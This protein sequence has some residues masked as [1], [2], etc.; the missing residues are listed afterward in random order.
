MRE[1]AVLFGRADSLVGI[2][3]DPPEGERGENLPA[4]VLLNGGVLHRVGPSRLHVKMARDLATLGFVV[5]RFDFSG[6]GD[7]QVRDDN[8]PFEKSAVRDTREAMDYLSAV[9]GAERFILIGICSGAVMSF[10]TACCDHRVTGVVVINARDYLHDVNGE[11]NSYINSRALA[12]HYWRIAFRSSFRSKN[13][14]KAATLAFDYRGVIGVM[15]SQLRGL[16]ARGRRRKVSPGVD[17]GRARLLALVERGVR[18]FLVYSEGDEGLD[19][20][21]VT[22]GNELWALSALGKVRVEIIQG[23]N[24]TFTLLWS[25]EHLLKVVHDWAQAV[26]Q[27]CVCAPRLSA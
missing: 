22:L 19:Y 18:L 21:H 12:R 20:L 17:N 9:R 15:G 16:F 4:V 14:L 2:V 26:V 10:V 25:Q 3:T 23:A 6:F 7:S 11:S 27:D 8:L 5:L 24:H 1:E 13:W